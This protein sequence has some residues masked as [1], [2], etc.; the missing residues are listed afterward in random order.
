MALHKPVGSDPDMP[1]AWL[2]ERTIDSSLYS[3]ALRNWRSQTFGSPSEQPEESQND[4]HTN[5]AS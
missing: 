3:Q 2:G 1:E 5:D 4:Q